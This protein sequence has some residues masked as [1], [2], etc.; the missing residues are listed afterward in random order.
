MKLLVTVVSTVITGLVG[1]FIGYLF[2]HW[3][4]NRIPRKKIIAGAVALSA[5]SALLVTW[6]QGFG[7]DSK[8]PAR[9]RPL[10]HLHHPQKPP[11]HPHRTPQRHHRQPLATTHPHTDL[12]SYAISLS[13]NRRSST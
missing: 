12:N 6:L 1:G 3:G 9:P 11:P 7:D 4:E 8:K 13:S 2:N 10:L 5:I